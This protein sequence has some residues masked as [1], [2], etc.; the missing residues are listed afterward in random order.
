MNRFLSW[1]GFQPIARLSFGIYLLH[2]L[3]VFH[4]IFTVKDVYILRDSLLVNILLKQCRNN[5]NSYYF[6]IF[7]DPK[8]DYRH[9]ERHIFG[10]HFLLIDRK[11][12]Y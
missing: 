3:V 10:L 1:H 9:H 5:F 7:L 11:A 8:L 4:R 12:V 2:F 6:G